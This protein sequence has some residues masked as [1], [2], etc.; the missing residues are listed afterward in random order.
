MQWKQHSLKLAGALRRGGAISIRFT[1]RVARA[2]RAIAVRGWRS[3]LRRRILR[4]V[5]VLARVAV[6]AV[7]L[8][9]LTVLAGGAFV[10]RVPP[11]DLV[12][13]QDNWGQGAGVQPRDLSPG[14]HLGTPGGTSWHVLDGRTV[15]IRF[16]AG[17]EGNPLPPLELRT[18]DDVELELSVTVPFRIQ[19]GRAH[20][21]VADGLKST[22]R[23][24]AKTAVEK[25][26]LERFASLR[27]DEWFS[28]DRRAAVAAEAL[29][30]V[31]EALD[32][33]HLVA[34]TVLVTRATL[35]QLYEQKLAEQKLNGLKLE[36]DQVLARR[37]LRKHDLAVEQRVVDRAE[38]DLGAD[39]DMRLERAKLELE[40]QILA[41]TTEAERYK[42]ERRVAAENL[43]AKSVATGQLAID[44]AEALRERL[45]NEAL[46]TDG[47]RLLLAQEAAGALKFKSIRIDGNRPDA[48]NVLDLDSFVQLL[49][50]SAARP[51]GE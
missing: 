50:G 26:L 43:Y 34:E 25:V 1:V 7:V 21:V 41:V 31:N 45:T 24:N 32:R 39:F 3:D 6:L 2:A 10:R 48:P 42:T 47:G 11:T 38:A 23:Q 33:I 18:L 46:E 40:G 13:R 27:S 14:F 49:V 15:F 28:T 30:A 35:P 36:T 9:G 12:V 8:A 51:K 17:G 20:R 37:E 29:T 19:E 22:Y 44:Q 5:F 16:G 4:P